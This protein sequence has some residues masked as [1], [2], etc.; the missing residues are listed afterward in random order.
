MQA[1]LTLFWGIVMS[2]ERRW[3]GGG[4]KAQI[5]KI[6]RLWKN[7]AYVSILILMYL[8]SG[9]LPKTWWGLAAM[10]WTIGWMVRYYNHTHGDYYH[11]ED[12]TPD[13][14][15]SWWVG[16][17]LKLIF[18]KGKYYNFVGNF[19]GLLLGYLVPALFASIFMPHHWFWVAGFTTTLSY[20]ACRIWLGKLANN[21]YAEWVG[22]FLT[23]VIFYLNL[24]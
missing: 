23:G 12:E 7:V 11:L 24:I 9:N 22:G 6:S 17:V 19:V 14:E 16:K 13:E 1:F 3:L 4:F 21:E 5:G 20:V 8:T 15:R 10:V 18:G 2:F